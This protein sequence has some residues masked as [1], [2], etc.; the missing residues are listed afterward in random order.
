MRDKGK[1]AG[2]GSGKIA[3]LTAEKENGDGRIE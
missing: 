1:G 3:S 2:G